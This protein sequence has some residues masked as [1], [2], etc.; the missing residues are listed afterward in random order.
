[1][2]NP[3]DR[4]QAPQVGAERDQLA[5][6]LDFLRAT[7]VW[8]ASGLTDEQSRR[9]LV[10]SKL[11]TVA[12]LVWHLTLVEEWWFGNVIGGEPDRWDEASKADP[13]VD[14]KPD[15]DTPLSLLVAGYRQR[16]EVNRRH[17]AGHEL[18]DVITA[19]NGRRFNV[20]W[21]LTHMIEETARHAGHLDLIREQLDGLVG[22]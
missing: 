16:C 22:E 15:P 14:W 3:D 11:L 4:P 2:T 21:V 5:G 18:D 20:R 1:V 7:V 10:P 19:P 9:S 12:G 17:L 6:F 8:K 13:D